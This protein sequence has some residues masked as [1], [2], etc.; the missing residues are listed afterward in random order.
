MTSLVSVRTYVRTSVR[1]QSHNSTTPVF[2]LAGSCMGCHP[3]LFGGKLDVAAR[4]CLAGSC[5]VNCVLQKKNFE[6]DKIQSQAMNKSNNMESKEREIERSREN[7][8]RISELRRERE[9]LR[10][11]ANRRNMSDEQREKEQARAQEKRRNFSE[12]QGEKE[13][14]SS[15]EKRQRSSEEQREKERKGGREKM[16][17]ISE[18]QR[19]RDTKRKRE[20]R[21]RSNSTQS[22]EKE[23]EVSNFN[24]SFTVNNL[25]ILLLLY[26]LFMTFVKRKQSQLFFLS[27]HHALL[28]KLTRASVVGRVRFSS[29]LFGFVWTLS[30]Q[31]FFFL[32]LPQKGNFFFLSQNSQFSLEK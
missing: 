25:K 28:V 12:E 30:R 19:Q 24:F 31:R 8:R 26:L 27:N 5:I 4:V 15:R 7:R 17:R 9:R 32:H 6:D 10:A 11:L 16:R 21:R 14:D 18:E 20:N 1:M 13:G 29:Y 3:P 22:K 2:V 23:E